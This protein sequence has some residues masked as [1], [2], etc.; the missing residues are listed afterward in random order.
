[1]K[2]ILIYG[3]NQQAKYILKTSLRPVF[4]TG[5]QDVY[6]DLKT[7]TDPSFWRR[8]FKVLKISILDALQPKFNAPF[9][10]SIQVVPNITTVG[11]SK[12]W[13]NG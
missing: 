1:M 7:L 2:L 9:Q 8:M 4:K 10:I 3:T 12:R 5:V 11:S 6:T 13:Y